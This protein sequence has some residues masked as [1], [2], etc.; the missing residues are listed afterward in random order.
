MKMT[1]CFDKSRD[2]DLSFP[3]IQFTIEIDDC[4]NITL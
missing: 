3:Y 1:F 4:R 2:F